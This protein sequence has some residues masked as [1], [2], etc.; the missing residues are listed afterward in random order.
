MMSEKDQQIELPTREEIFANYEKLFATD[1]GAVRRFKQSGLRYIQFPG[2]MILVEQNPNKQSQWA[3]LALKG[4]QIAWLMKEGDYL[5]RVIDG[6]V[7]IL[8]RR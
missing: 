7:E 6:E 5:A 4:H 2:G 8:S 3:E 1:K